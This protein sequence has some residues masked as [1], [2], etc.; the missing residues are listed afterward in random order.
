M[1]DAY[2]QRL[3][4]QQFTLWE[5]LIQDSVSLSL[6]LEITAR[7]NN[8]CRHCCINLPAG[9]SKSQ[10]EEL[11][12]DEIL[13]LA[14]QAVQ[15]GAVWCLLTGGE[16]LLRADF[17]DIYL[18]LKRMG[19]LVGVF[20]NATLVDERCVDLF[21]R[22]PPRDL[23][24]TVYGVTQST[25]EAVTRRSGSFAA[26]Q[27]GLQL[28]LDNGLPVRLKSMTLRSNLH[29]FSQIAEFCRCH[30]KDYYRFDP[31]LNLRYDR[32]PQR[33]AEIEGQR[34]TPKEIVEIE[35]TDTERFRAIQMSCGI[36]NQ[37]EV[38][39]TNCDHL[40]HCGAGI[41]GFAVGYNGLFRVCDGLWAP[42]TVCDLRKSTLRQALS[43]LV[44]RVRGM[45]VENSAFLSTCRVCPIVNFCVACPAH[46]YLETGHMDVATPYFCAVAKERA[47]TIDESEKMKQKLPVCDGGLLERPNGHQ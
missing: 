42:E 37:P 47:R 2:C 7:C 41:G 3:E 40:F 31:F 17:G 10:A 43:Y 28:L 24:V 30:T 4:F 34:L 16:P 38:G 5:R 14:S 6:T 27:R 22:Y 33:N 12:L 39:H 23:E 13:H 25:Y 21:K 26:F 19:L 45:R 32:N 15:A 1:E 46:N 11:T 44:P 8:D 36:L 18:G 9:D 35:Q 29:E 20:T